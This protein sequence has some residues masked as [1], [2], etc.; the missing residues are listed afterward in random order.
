M[1]RKPW[2]VKQGPP[3]QKRG[4]PMKHR[5]DKRMQD[6]ERREIELHLGAEDK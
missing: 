5:L 1:K 4:G 2:R 6:K 3:I